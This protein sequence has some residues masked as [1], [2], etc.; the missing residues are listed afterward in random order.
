MNFNQYTIKAQEVIQKASE[1]ALANGQQ[2]IETGHILKAILD[3]D[4]NT[5]AFLLKKAGAKQEIIQAK[6]ETIIAT[7]PKV[8]GDASQLYLSNDANQALTKTANLIKE[9]GDEFVSV[10]LLLLS[11]AAGK[12]SVASLLKENSLNEKNLKSAIK[13]LRG[14]NTV[15]DQNAENKYQALWSFTELRGN[16]TVK[17]QN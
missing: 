3:E 11:L 17:D 12:D 4:A 6:L 15:K 2:A 9:F 5:S 1:I 16:N 13:E 8:S 10:E 14:N 7:Y